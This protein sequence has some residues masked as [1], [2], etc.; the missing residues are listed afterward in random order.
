M[1]S[2]AALLYGIG[3][4]WKVE[5]I[6]I[7]D[8]GPGEVMVKTKAA[9]LC[10]SDEHMVTGDMLMPHYPCIGGHEGAGEVIAVGAGVTSVAVG[11]HVSMSFVPS[12]GRCK[13]CVSGRSNLCDLGAK[14]FDVGMMTDGRM[15]HH[16][17]DLDLARMCQLGTFAEHV[18]VSE[19]GIVKVEPDLPWHAAALVSCGVATGF[20]SSVNRA[21]VRPGDTVAIIGVG[22][23]GINA[24]Q[25]AK[26]A[27]AKRVIAIDPVEFKREKAMEFGA[28][29]TFS[30]IDEAMLAV[31]DLTW[32]D[33]CD[34]VIITVGVMKGE[35]IEP[36]LSLTGKGG[37]C[38]MTSVAS[39][40]D[41]DASL[42]SFMFAMMNK[43]LKGTLFGSGNPRFEIPNL[44]SMYREGEL[45]L[46]ELVTR[47][48]ALDQIN[49]GYQDM[50]DG[51]NIRGVIEFD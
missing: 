16:K 31:P 35:L 46:D 14:L 27:G 9:G 40:L 6:T 50:R 8:P 24:V 32:G 12:C 29:H 20:G 30:S 19:A 36:A 25:G 28:T 23:V 26:I 13:W 45:K 38:V 3:E 22:G 4:D 5:D 2:R 17:G 34:K 44:L 1:K 49:E 33:M 21:Q 37:T 48:Y 42:N 11:D 15:A 18:L 7:D 41:N 47:T 10:H 39:M 51:K 43:E